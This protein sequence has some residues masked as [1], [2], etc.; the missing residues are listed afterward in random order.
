M[1]NPEA[2]AVPPS[3][4]PFFSLLDFILLGFL[5]GGAAWWLLK[6]KKKEPPASVKSYSIQ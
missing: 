4:E 3:E 1:D 2:T 6:N 5:I